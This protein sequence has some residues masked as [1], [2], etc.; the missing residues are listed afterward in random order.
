MRDHGIDYGFSESALDW[1]N[2]EPL[3]PRLRSF[4]DHNSHLL[5]QD[6]KITYVRAQ[7]S[8]WVVRER[9]RS[10]ADADA[11]MRSL[12]EADDEQDTSEHGEAEG[13]DDTWSLAEGFSAWLAEICG[14]TLRP[15]FE[16]GSL[17]FLRSPSHQAL[18]DYFG[19]VPDTSIHDVPVHS[20]SASMFLPKQSVWNFRRKS[21]AEQ[22][23][24]TAPP[25][26]D[27]NNDPAILGW[28]CEGIAEDFLGP[29]HELWNTITSDFVSREKG[30]KTHLGHTAI[31]ERNFLMT[32]P[33][34][35]YLRPEECL[36]CVVAI[37]EAEAQGDDE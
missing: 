14:S 6:A 37:A 4:I 26:S 20:L 33:N 1:L 32:A 34:G 13:E 25:N 21:R 31:D 3:A 36:S 17:A 29:F 18:M 5:H 35:R 19:Q 15:N 10:E 22:A 12:F 27:A 28:G 23:T 9:E 24:P 2:L 30:P 11:Q 8:D 16:L 7:G